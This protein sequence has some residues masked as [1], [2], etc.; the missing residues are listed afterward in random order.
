V[1]RTA[2]RLWA[3]LTILAEDSL[4]WGNMARWSIVYRCRYGGS[5]EDVALHERDI[6]G[7]SR[8][9]A[10]ERLQR[11]MVGFAVQSLEI[12]EVRAPLTRD[13]V[14]AVHE[15]NEQLDA[16]RRRLGI[17]GGPGTEKNYYDWLTTEEPGA[18]R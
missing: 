4:G 5:R 18:K 11:R 17:F 6:I 16:E 2:E 15:A 7:S 8:A 13:Q 1:D 14:V 12:F 10:I 3:G 9:G